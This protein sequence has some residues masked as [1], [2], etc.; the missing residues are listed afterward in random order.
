MKEYGLTK[1]YGMH[2]VTHARLILLM[3]ENPKQ[4]GTT[5]AV[6]YDKLSAE[7]R[8]ELIQMIDA[9]ECQSVKDA[10]TALSKKIFQDQPAYTALDYLNK[11]GY[12]KDYNVQDITMFITPNDTIP[13]TSLIE[14]CR[15]YEAKRF[16]TAETSPFGEI[17]VPVSSETYPEP[18]CNTE[19][20]CSKQEVTSDN[21]NN[22]NDMLASVLV[23]MMDRLEDVGNKLDA[24]TETKKVSSKRVKK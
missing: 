18:T 15:Q 24:L 16:N 12:I 5:K 14:Q 17:E 1:H 19:C 23:K 2:N 3:V 6:E 11:F 21:T 22:S 7:I 13:L 8:S 9:P 10:W 20:S 4:R